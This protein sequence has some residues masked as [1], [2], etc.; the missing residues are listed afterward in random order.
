MAG[1]RSTAT[2]GFAGV[3]GEHAIAFQGIQELRA[4]NGTEAFRHGSFGFVIG[5]IIDGV[6]VAVIASRGGIYGR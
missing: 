2:L 6:I 1:T 3:G 4:R 5:L